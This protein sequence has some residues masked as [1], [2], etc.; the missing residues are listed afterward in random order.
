MG[1]R[2]GCHSLNI[3]GD[4]SLQVQGPGRLQIGATQQPRVMRCFNS[5]LY[6]CLRG[7]GWVPSADWTTTN[8]KEGAADGQGHD[9]SITPTSASGVGDGKQ[10]QMHKG[11][12]DVRREPPETLGR[13]L[14]FPLDVGR[15]SNNV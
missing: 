5:L 2:L 10:R 15:G 12:G 11:K 7:E 9:C 1:V 3:H 14:E 8:H 6:T 4:T 13:P